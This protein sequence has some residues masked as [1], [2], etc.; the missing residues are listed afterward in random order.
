VSREKNRTDILQMKDVGFL[1]W[2]VQPATGRLHLI[3]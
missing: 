3:V 2:F 1:N